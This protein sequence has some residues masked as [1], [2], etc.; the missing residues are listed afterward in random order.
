MKL[1]TC[2]STKRF[3]AKPTK[4][5]AA[6]VSTQIAG[7]SKVISDSNFIEAIKNGQTFTLSAGFKDNIRKAANFKGIQIFA[8]DIDDSNYSLKEIQEKAN[9]FSLGE[10]FA[11]YESFS[12]T[13]ETKKWRVL[14]VSDQLVTDPSIALA[15]LRKIR[16]H[17]DSDRAI[18]DLA[19]MLYGTTKDKVRQYT[20]H[21]FNPFTLNLTEELNVKKNVDSKPYY[22]TPGKDKKFTKKFE[23]VKKEVRYTFLYSD[24]SGYMTIWHG[25][26]K[27]AATGIVSSNTIKNMIFAWI[28]QAERFNGYHRSD[29]E[30]EQLIENAINWYNNLE[31]TN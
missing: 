20:G 18:I 19:R 21:A 17:Y 24:E 14:Y 7:Q 31:D 15:I 2:L 8:A 9:S 30:I 13:E 11:I 4:V 29:E 22:K 16:N 12:S 1:Q 25:A 3:T 6:L 5:D 26:R 28:E 27:L 10:P 23:Q